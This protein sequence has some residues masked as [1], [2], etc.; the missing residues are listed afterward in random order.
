LIGRH[1]LETDEREGAP[2]VV[3]LGEGLWRNRFA[4]DP[5]IVGRTMQLGATPHMVVGVMPESFAF[6]IN[7]RAWV[8]LREDRSGPEPL[9]GPELMVFGRLAPHA[10]LESAQAELAALGRR[11][12]LASPKHYAHLRPSVMPYAYPFT[13]LHQMK[14]LEALDLMQRLSTSLLV[15]VAFNVAI[16]VY[17]RTATRQGEISVRTALGASR[18]RIVTQLFVEALALSVPAALA[19][20]AIA[21]LALRMIAAAT[22]QIALDLPFWVTFHLSAAAV[23]WAGALS[24]LAAMIVGIVPALKSTGRDVQAGLKNLG[25]GGSGLRLGATWTALIV[26][27]VG[28]A[29]ALMPAS[30]FH[31]WRSWESG[32]ADPQFAANEFLSVQLTRDALRAGDVP[33]PASS[34]HDEL[35]RRLKADSRVSAVTFAMA[36]PGEETTAWIEIQ[37]RAAVQPEALRHEVRVNHVDVGFFQTFEVPLL[38]GRGL[39]PADISRTG[40]RPAIPRTGGNIVVNQSLAARIFGGDA[41]GRRIRYAGRRGDDPS[42]GTGSGPWHEIVGVVRDFPEGVSPGMDDSPLKLYHAAEAGQLTPVTLQLRLRGGEPTTFAARLR[43]I[44]ASVDPDLQLL[45]IVS[46]DEALRREQ[47]IRRLEA[48]VLAA[49][50]LSV[51]MLSAA[52]I[53]ALMSLT[54]SQRRKEI[55]IRT[56]LGASGHRLIAGIFARSLGQLGAGAALG[57]ASA[58]LLE[59]FSGGTLLQGNAYGVLPVVAL[60]M[61]SVGAIAA[62]GPVL[63]S[64]RLQPTEALRHQ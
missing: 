52:G 29:V 60:F 5:A 27:Q 2:A 8:P 28:F 45:N 3:V 43:E 30:V 55:G 21:E 44:A 58:A 1:L 41:L 49:L 18:A 32:M 53:Y 9:T 26:A 48:A 33:G 7:H 20:V 34:P 37:Q 15:L 63:R 10:T 24:V 25:T 51:L 46:L 12:A 40:D 31:A 62:I 54:V 47:W 4:A 59:R 13:G 64:L 19:G 11:S 35:I 50:T 23:L 6:P 17:S 61:V 36:N 14:D 57:M 16:L 56:A 38:A 22:V 42:P 39:E